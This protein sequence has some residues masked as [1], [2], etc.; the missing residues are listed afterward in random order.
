MSLCI[1]CNTQI[2]DKTVFAHTYN[3][4]SPLKRHHMWINSEIQPTT[5]H[6]FVFK[7]SLSSN[8]E[9]ANWISLSLCVLERLN[10]NNFL[11]Y[12]TY[13]IQTRTNTYAF[14]YSIVVM[15]VLRFCYIIFNPLRPI[16]S[17]PIR[18]APLRSAP[19]KD[20]LEPH[21]FATHSQKGLI[22]IKEVLLVLSF[23]HLPHL[24]RTEHTHKM[25]LI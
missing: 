5:Y 24:L 3:D 12:T 15:K 18:S 16:P 25:T 10:G 20:K 6:H 19:M 22:L 21:T 14:I 4:E 11:H 2:A 8:R 7:H 13:S 1:R 17:D 9:I 23:R